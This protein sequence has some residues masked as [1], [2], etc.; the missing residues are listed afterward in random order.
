MELA[1]GITRTLK[2]C[3]GIKPPILAQSAQRSIQRRC[4]Q[5]HFR[6]SSSQLGKGEVPG[7]GKTEIK[8]EPFGKEKLSFRGQLYRSTTER[9]E[10]EQALEDRFR[11]MRDEKGEGTPFRAVSITFSTQARNMVACLC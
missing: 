4:Q 8:D 2:Q 11:R 7:E 9:L 1:R 3:H 10:R 5:R 6:W